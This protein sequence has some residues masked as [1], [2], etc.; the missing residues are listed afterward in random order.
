[1]TFFV[2]VDLTIF[3]RF[4]STCDSRL[5]VHQNKELQRA[6]VRACMCVCV[7]ACVG[8]CVRMYVRVRTVIA[9]GRLKIMMT[10]AT[11]IR[12]VLDKEAI[13]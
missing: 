2:T 13:S 1:M 7:L 3:I 9:R 5:L 6:L 4:R 12:G 11:F 8:V 10:A